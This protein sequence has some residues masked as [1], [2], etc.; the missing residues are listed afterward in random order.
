MLIAE[1]DITESVQLIK[2]LPRAQSIYAV[3]VIRGGSS[4][5]LTHAHIRIIL[6]ARYLYWYIYWHFSNDQAQN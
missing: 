6:Y 4:L 5:Q 3:M 2:I 1:P